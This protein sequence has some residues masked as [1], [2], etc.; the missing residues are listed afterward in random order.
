MG[1]EDGGALIYIYI[2]T[3]LS[4]LLPFFFLKRWFGWICSWDFSAQVST[5]LFEYVDW[6]LL[7]KKDFSWLIWLSMAILLPSIACY[8]WASQLQAEPPKMG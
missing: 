1:G 3:Y 6:P 8:Q 2:Y 7:G 5:V 4:F